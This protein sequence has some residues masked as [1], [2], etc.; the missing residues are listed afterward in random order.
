[1]DGKGHRR[2]DGVFSDMHGSRY[3]L[4]AE[5]GDVIF[6]GATDFSEQVSADR[7]KARPPAHLLQDN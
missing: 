7:I 2:D 3:D 6:E 1:M 4:L 5:F